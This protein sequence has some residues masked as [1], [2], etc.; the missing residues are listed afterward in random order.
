VF[1]LQKDYKQSYETLV[2]LTEDFN[3]YD[4]W[5]G[6]AYLLMAD[7]FVAMDQIFQA[8]ATLQSLIDNFPLKHIKDAAAAKIRDI[9]K[10][11]ADKKIEM[12]ADTLESDTLDINR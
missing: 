10:A 5:V 9:D 2:S 4:E 3:S 7:N 1:Y 8:R 12:E 6:K 11:E